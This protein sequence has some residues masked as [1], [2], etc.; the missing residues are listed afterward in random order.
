MIKVN[1]FKSKC[2]RY[3]W[4]LDLYISDINKTLI[5]IGLNPSLSDANFLDNTTKKIIKISDNY[6]YGKVRIINLFG[7]I[8]K[9]PKILFLHK[10]PIGNI[11]NK[12][13]EESMKYWSL[14]FNCNIWLGWGNNG[15]CLNRNKDV[16]SL[17]K[18]Y[19]YLK[20]NNFKNPSRPL[21]IKKT[22][23]N[24]PIHPLYCKNNSILNEDFSIFESN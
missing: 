8:S 15:V 21:L 19:F 3:R 7:L 16:Y 6:N 9:D 10:D 14:N 18:K 5:F 11:N 20:K 1:C 23:F 12:I 13:I 4:V 22:K 24:N 17:I 2:K